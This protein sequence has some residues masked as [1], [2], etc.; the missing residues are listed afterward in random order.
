MPRHACDVARDAATA[1][2]HAE[3]RDG[4]P[5]RGAHRRYFGSVGVMRAKPRPVPRVPL[6]PVGRPHHHSPLVTA[7]PHVG[8]PTLP[9][10]PCRGP[11]DDWMTVLPPFQ[12]APHLFKAL[13]SISRARATRR[14]VA[15]PWLT[16]TASSIFR[17][18]SLPTKA[19]TTSPRT[20]WS[21]HTRLLL[22]LDRRL[23]GVTTP[24]PPPPAYAVPAAGLLLAASKHPNQGHV[25]PRPS[26]VASPA[27]TAGE[28][29][30]I[31]PAALPPLA[32]GLH[33][34]A[35][36]LSRVVCAN[37]GYICEPLILSKGLFAK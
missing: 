13:S 18:L 32:R 11:V 3:A 5:V 33:C 36:V 1:R 24:R 4:P 34:M 30:G 6:P 7:P 14:V 26:P 23:A 16:R 10:L 29:A 31:W 17:S 15:M 21:L 22:R 8:A 19:T 12:L 27:K 20:R 35:G 2:A 9:Y 28:V 25:D 37:Q